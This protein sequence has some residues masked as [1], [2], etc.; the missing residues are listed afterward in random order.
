MNRLAELREKIGAWEQS[1]QSIGNQDEK[2]ERLVREIR[3][4]GESH[5]YTNSYAILAPWLNAFEA[6]LVEQTKYEAWQRDVEDTVGNP[7]ERARVYAVRHAMLQTHRDN[8]TVHLAPDW[9]FNYFNPRL[10]PA[11]EVRVDDEPSVQAKP[12]F[13]VPLASAQFAH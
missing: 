4:I 8:D 11:M 2:R 9:L 10:G 6:S 7:Q 13:L 5:M 1:W 3:E 12:V